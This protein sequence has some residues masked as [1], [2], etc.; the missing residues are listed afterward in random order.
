M[1]K[2][3]LAAVNEYSNSEIAAKYALALARSCHAKLF[4]VF[5][6]EK[7]TGTAVLK[8]AELAMERLFLEAKDLHIDAESILAEGDPVRKLSKKV[9]EN[10]VDLVFISTRHQDVRKQLFQR[11]YA[12]KLILHLPC[13]VA[14]VRVVHMQRIHPRHI[15]V[16][17][18]GAVTRLDERAYF[19]S[20]LAKA[21]DST[22]T[23]F[24]S[25]M[26][27]SRFL[28]GETKLKTAE[29][30]ENIPED[31][32]KFSDSLHV[33]SIPSEKRVEYGGISRT[34]TIEAARKR[35]DLIVMGASERGLVSSLISGSPVEQVLRETPCNLIILRPKMTAV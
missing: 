23:L 12:E 24:H 17:L 19:V 25:S 29:R 9:K 32:R 21:F 20:M 2:N 14:M 10:G 8:R 1:Y 26:P 27:I 5:V 16:P 3:I 4:L 35:N 7:K 18:R 31:I 34:I 13:S 6:A 11:S 15:L 22:V 28:H 33:H 30:L